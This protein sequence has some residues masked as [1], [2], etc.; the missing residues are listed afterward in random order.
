MGLFDFKKN[1]KI[2]TNAVNKME[3]LPAKKTSYV[4]GTNGEP[5]LVYYREKTKLFVN[6][7]VGNEQISY[8]LNCI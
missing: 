6:R 1:N 2:A 8:F 7:P 3:I 4:V 5:M